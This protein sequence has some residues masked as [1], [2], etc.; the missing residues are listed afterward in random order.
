MKI[1]AQNERE[2]VYQMPGS[3]VLSSISWCTIRFE[4]TKALHPEK[5][6]A[7]P[8]R[9]VSNPPASAINSVPAA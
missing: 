6:G 3:R 2:R 4:A 1:A 8:S 9:S 7:F 5:S